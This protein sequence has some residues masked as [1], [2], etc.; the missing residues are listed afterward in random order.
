LRLALGH[1]KRVKP[2]AW[3]IGMKDKQLFVDFVSFCF[4]ILEY[5]GAVPC[6]IA[7]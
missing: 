5:F 1:G 3:K 2:G 7:A 4:A 6:R